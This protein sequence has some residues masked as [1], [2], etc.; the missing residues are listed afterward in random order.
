MEIDLPFYDD[1]RAYIQGRAGL[2]DLGYLFT[3]ENGT[4]YPVGKML[5]AIAQRYLDGNSV[6]Y[7]FLSMTIVLGSLLALQWRL[8]SFAMKDR[9]FAASAFSLTVFMLQPGSYWGHQN[10]A[11]HQAVPLLCLVAVLALGCRVRPYRANGSLPGSCG[12]WAHRWS[13]LHVGRAARNCSSDRAF[14]LCAL[15]RSGR[16]GPTDL[17]RRRFIGRGHR[18]DSAAAPACL[19]NNRVLTDAG[20]DRQS[21]N[22]AQ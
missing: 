17:G 1:W 6:A 12:A 14:G 20:R 22:L 5:D 8:L 18:N 13:D 3:P 16:P 9:L 10:L 11:Y 21:I 2:L 15:S 7:Q 4:Y 19:R